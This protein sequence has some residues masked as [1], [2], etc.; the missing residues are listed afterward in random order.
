MSQTP[1]HDQS[2]HD[3]DRALPPRAEDGAADAER[4]EPDVE[5]VTFAPV[6]PVIGPEEERRAY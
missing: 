1:D 3:D 5:G 4:A 2:R 6:M